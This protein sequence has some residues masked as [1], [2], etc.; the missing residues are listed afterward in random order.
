MILSEWPKPLS[1]LLLGSLL[2]LTN[3]GV[4]SWN[5]QLYCR[6]SSPGF[7]LSIHAVRFL[8]TAAVLLAIART[9]ASSLLSALAGFQVVRI[10]VLHL[11][12]LLER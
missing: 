8:G 5:V 2:G 10:V 4:L 11:E 1:W 3:L 9:G 6:R 12:C 7:A